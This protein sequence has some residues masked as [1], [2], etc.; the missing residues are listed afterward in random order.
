M[1]RGPNDVS[2]KISHFC[3]VSSGTITYSSKGLKKTTFSFACQH[4]YVAWVHFDQENQGSLGTNELNE[5]LRYVFLHLRSQWNERTLVLSHWAL[6]NMAHI[7]VKTLI[8]TEVQYGREGDTPAPVTG[9]LAK[10]AQS[11]RDTCRQLDK[12]Y[13][14]TG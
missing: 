3:I 7:V 2:R 13:H 12:S 4:K 5:P 11:E 6:L 14:E 10:F 9:V 1:G 8:R